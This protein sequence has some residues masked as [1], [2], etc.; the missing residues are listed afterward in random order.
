MN[1]ESRTEAGQA[2]EQDMNA[3]TEEVG[4][5]RS[6]L[7]GLVENVGRIGRER[8]HAITHNETLTHGIAAGEAALDGAAKELRALE[9]DIADA[10]RAY[11]WRALGIAAILGF[12]FGFLAR[13]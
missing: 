9:Q 10:T 13:R 7:A 1:T 3:I 12:L 2:A 8:V 4:K 11:P 5:L 6:E